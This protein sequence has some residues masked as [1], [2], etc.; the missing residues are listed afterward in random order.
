[1]VYGRFYSNSIYCAFQRV[2]GTV[3]SMW[4]KDSGLFD[5]E[6]KS[7][8]KW[9][10]WAGRILTSWLVAD[11]WPKFASCVSC[12]VFSPVLCSLRKTLCRNVKTLTF[13]VLVWMTL[14]NVESSIW[15]VVLHQG[16]QKHH[17]LLI[18]QGPNLA[19]WGQE[20]KYF[21][22]ASIPSCSVKIIWYP[23]FPPLPHPLNV[24]TPLHLA[25]GRIFHYNICS[26][27]WHFFA[28]KMCGCK[29]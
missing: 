9:L 1:M 8:T 10:R 22:G 7:R 18:E 25:K 15:F 3:L 6:K 14:V 24:W 5:R 4:G 29:V 28:S 12:L 27:S 26:C 16:I 11:S 23:L 21:K 19:G 13:C 17:P 20:K 2:V